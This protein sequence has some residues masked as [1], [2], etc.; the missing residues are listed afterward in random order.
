MDL[1]YQTYPSYPCSTLARSTCRRSR[2]ADPRVGRT[3]DHTAPASSTRS[4]TTADSMRAGPWSAASGD[5]ISD[6]S[7]I[8]NGDHATSTRPIDRSR[9]ISRPSRVTTAS[10]SRR[11]STPPGTSTAPTRHRTKSTPPPIAKSAPAITSTAGSI[12]GAI[13]V[14]YSALMRSTSGASSLVAAAI[15]SSDNA[16]CV[17]A[18]RAATGRSRAR[19]VSTSTVVH[20]RSLV[21]SVRKLAAR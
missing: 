2:R 12:P 20:T 3:M 11:N 10:P 8:R 19:S 16:G 4:T 14:A 18:T 15:D 9:P 21:S 5:G 7:Q 13:F 17:V 6:A 1:S